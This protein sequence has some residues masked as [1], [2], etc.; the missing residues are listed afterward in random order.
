MTATRHSF[1]PPMSRSATRRLSSRP[2][3]QPSRPASPSPRR[4]SPS[5]SP[6]ATRRCPSAAAQ[7][8]VRSAASTPSENNGA[9][10]KAISEQLA[11]HGA[12][13]ADRVYLNFFD[14]PRANCGWSGRT[15][16]G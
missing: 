2:A 9:L 14:V 3:P 7:I 12:V 16:A 10:T 5:V 11:A 15:F 13:P 6:T 4:T 1:S 8:R